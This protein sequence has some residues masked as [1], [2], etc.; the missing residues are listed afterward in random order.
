MH[1]VRGKLSCIGRFTQKALLGACCMLC[2]V[3]L[4]GKIICFQ[5]LV[6]EKIHA[7]SELMRSL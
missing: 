5:L 6:R 4:Q 1:T 2:T 7:K 3:F